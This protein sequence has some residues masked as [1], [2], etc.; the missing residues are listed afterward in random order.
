[1]TDI[2]L[3]L[4]SEASGPREGAREREESGGGAGEGEACPGDVGVLVEERVEVGRQDGV[5]QEWTG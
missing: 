2:T 5:G 4:T 3:T 1:M